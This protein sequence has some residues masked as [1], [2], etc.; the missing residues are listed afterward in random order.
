[1]NHGYGRGSYTDPVDN[2]D[3][4]SS[5]MASLSTTHWPEIEKSGVD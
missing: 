2:C 3:S 5:H 4:G 1:M